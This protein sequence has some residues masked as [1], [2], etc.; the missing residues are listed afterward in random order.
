MQYMGDPQ[1]IL[2][3]DTTPGLSELGV[4]L[5]VNYRPTVHEGSIGSTG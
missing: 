3:K 1:D 4:I 5:Q 2:D